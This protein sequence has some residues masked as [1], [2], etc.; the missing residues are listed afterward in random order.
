M[1]GLSVN[2]TNER[3]IRVKRFAMAIRNYE[4]FMKDS[5]YSIQFDSILFNDNHI[6]LS[7]FSF[8]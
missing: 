3:P 5:S 4:N 8:S 2:Q 6:N 7:K 1:Q